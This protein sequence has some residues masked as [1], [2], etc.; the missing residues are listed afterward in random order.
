MQLTNTSHLWILLQESWTEITESF[1]MSVLSLVLL[2]DR[3]P[4][5]DGAEQMPKAATLRNQ[6]CNKLYVQINLLNTSE[7]FYLYDV[8]LL[9]LKYNQCT[10]MQ[11][12]VS[13]KIETF[14][15]VSKKF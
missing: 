10:I 6:Q 4:H 7:L 3:I 12:R 11:C 9:L 5:T 2:V 15:W 14:H 8:L 13:C 1:M